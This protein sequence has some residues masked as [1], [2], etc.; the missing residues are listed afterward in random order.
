[1]H[2]PVRPPFADP[3][4]TVSGVPIWL[5]LVGRSG[6]SEILTAGGVKIKDIAL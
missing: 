4:P 2:I 6:S 5:I 3:I 1:V